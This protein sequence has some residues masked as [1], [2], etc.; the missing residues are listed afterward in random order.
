MPI[1]PGKKDSAQRSQHWKQSTTSQSLIEHSRGSTLEELRVEQNIADGA[2]GEI[3][4][5]EGLGP[6][7]HRYIR[8]PLDPPQNGG[9]GGVID[10]RHF[11]ESANVPL[12]L[13]E[14]VGAIVEFDQQRRGFPSAHYEEDYK[15]NFLG[16]VFRNNYWEN[17]GDISNEFNEFFDDYNRGELEGFWPTVDRTVTD[18]SERGVEGVEQLGGFIEDYARRSGQQGLQQL[19][20]LQ[21][22]IQNLLQI[23][24]VDGLRRLYNQLTSAEQTLTAQADNLVA[25]QS[26]GEKS[27]AKILVPPEQQQTGVIS[28]KIPE[29]T[30]NQQQ[31]KGENLSAQSY[32]QLDPSS[33]P[34]QEL[35]QWVQEAEQ[36]VK[37]RPLSWVYSS[38]EHPNVND[39]RT[40]TLKL[41]QEVG[42]QHQQANSL[43]AQREA[44]I[45]QR[46]DRGDCSFFNPGGMTDS[47]QQ[48][49]SRQI[50][51]IDFELKDLRDTFNTSQAKLKDS[52]D[53][54]NEL[55]EWEASPVNQT[56]LAR[57]AMIENN[58]MLQRTI[59]QYA[60]IDQVFRDAGLA[61]TAIGDL[62]QLDNLQQ[63]YQQ[64]SQE[65]VMP[66]QQE[67][68]NLESLAQNFQNQ[69]AAAPVTAMEDTQLSMG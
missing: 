5:G 64:F 33:L 26:L 58:P 35:L 51:A 29:Q 2:Q 10:M 67:M 38:V 49:T 53:F 59:E 55:Q 11:L 22:S 68:Q 34:P 25:Q 47:Q 44:L 3:P 14:G 24:P 9:P 62:S 42:D 16:V 7:G 40:E 46:D 66:S 32:G 21:E 50:E 60:A 8:D 65:G 54:H 23:N 30:A 52:I 12:S 43:R 28:E 37:S 69:Q 19:R 39:V 31:R 6:A 13:G 63:Q 15:S 45:A 17:D 56:A 20:N 61:L 27:Q 48:R 57:V 18:L 4:W 36:S 1:L 41:N